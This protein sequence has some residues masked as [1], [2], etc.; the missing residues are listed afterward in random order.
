MTGI[1]SHLPNLQI[2]LITAG[3]LLRLLLAMD[4]AEDPYSPS[5][6]NW[7]VFKLFCR[8]PASV[9][10]DVISFQASWTPEDA[11]EVP[12]PPMFYCTWSRELQDS[13]R[14]VP[15]TRA[16]QIQWAIDPGTDVMQDF[17]A[18]S[19]DFPDLE[20]FFAAVEGSPQFR[21]L[22]ASEGMGELYTVDADML[23]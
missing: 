6:S 17:E 22:I 10:S 11:A 16:V 5:E 12:D 20:S 19:D 21:C 14:F 15:E 13:E 2:N 3:P 18:W 1:V 8:L 7:E 23:K 9:T 4:D